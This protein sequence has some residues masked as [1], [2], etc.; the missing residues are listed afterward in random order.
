MPARR[1][2]SS[3]P[4]APA[5]HHVQPVTGDLAPVGGTHPLC[6]RGHHR[7]PAAS[8]LVAVG[9]G[10]SLPDSAS[11]RGMTVFENL[12]VAAVFGDRRRARPATADCRRRAGAAPGCSAKANVAARRSDPAGAQAARARARARDSAPSAAARRDRRRAHRERMPCTDRDH[13]G[14]PCARR[15]S[16]GSSTSSMRCFGGRA[17]LWSS[18]SAGMLAEGEPARGDGRPARCRESTSGIEAA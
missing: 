6:R 11:L 16:S 15:P 10:R 7:A 2:A 12:L 4:T 17:G 9:I 8:A 13:P 1:S 5:S 14:H 18:I 3:A